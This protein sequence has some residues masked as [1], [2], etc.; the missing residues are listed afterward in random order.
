[1]EY[2]KPLPQY[3][4][5]V[6][7]RCFTYN[8]SKFIA[9]TLEGFVSQQT[10]FP[11]VCVVVDDCST[12]GEQEVIKEWIIQNCNNSPSVF[13]EEYTDIYIIEHNYNAN[14]TLV[15][16]LLKKNH[17]S[18][19]KPKAPYVKAWKSASNYVALCEGDD[20]WTDPNKLQI[21]ADF[22]DTHL[23]YSAVATQSMVIYETG[24]K[25]RPFSKHTIDYDW[26]RGS[27]VGYRPFHTATIMYRPCAELDNR[28]SVYS[29]DISIMIILSQKG[30]WRL[31]SRNT[32]IYRKHSGGASSN[33]KLSD[34]KRDLNGIPY[35]LALNPNFPIR[36]YKAYLYYTFS[37]YP[38]H[39]NLSTIVKYG[40]QSIINSLTC[41]PL[42]I[43][44]AA[45]TLYYVLKKIRTNNY[46]RHS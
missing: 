44:Q 40:A 38:P 24:D 28:P 2:Q 23:D 27:L 13:H 4:F 41:Y 26:E 33:V 7:I 9:Q 35:Y 3:N 15:F 42:D 21:Q 16:Y 8:H 32:S 6:M 22:L 34:L 11:F 10:N 43:Y 14:C 1:M 39:N 20:Y 29:G 17:K 37:T 18:Q 45:R 19:R 12:D 5:K 25:S 30:K 31:M 46:F 36:R